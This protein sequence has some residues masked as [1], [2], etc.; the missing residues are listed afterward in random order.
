MFKH[1]I[2]GRRKHSSVC[3]QNNMS[4]HPTRVW[5]L[6][7]GQQEE[8]GRRSVRSVNGNEWGIPLL[9]IHYCCWG[10]TEETE[11]RRWSE[12]RLQ[13]QHQQ[14]IQ[15]LVGLKTS[16]GPTSAGPASAPGPTSAPGSTSAAGL[17]SPVSLT[18]LC[19]SAQIILLCFFLASY[20]LELYIILSFNIL[21]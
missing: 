9:H 15:H 6:T 19:R 16:A 20:Y 14:H 17:T 13:D 21:F 7:W 10:L 4:L 5:G 18:E 12:H 11:L 2:N 3:S 1:F 8:T